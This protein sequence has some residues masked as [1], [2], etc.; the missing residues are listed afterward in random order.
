LKEDYGE[1]MDWVER[2]ITIAPSGQ[3]KGQGYFYRTFINF[4]CGRYTQ[5]L[6]EADQL[7]MMANLAGE[8]EGGVNTELLKGWILYEQGKPELSREHYKHFQDYYASNPLGKDSA[9]ALYDFYDGYA[10]LEMGRLD[11][12]QKKLDAYK[13]VLT[14]AHN[15]PVPQVFRY[16]GGQFEGEVLLRFG[17]AD[18]AVSNLEKAPSRGAPPATQYVLPLY[19]QPFAMDALARAYREMRDID[20]AIAEYEKLTTFNPARPE[21]NWIHPKYHFRLAELYELKGLKDRA[22]DSYQKFLGIWKNADPD[23]PEVAKAKMRL[24]ALQG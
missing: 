19:V 3:L 14:N 23:I 16:L 5:A 8:K 22:I 10:D 11:S 12:A 20:N 15:L 7:L 13:F 2:F 17:S 9:Q 1:A 4:W 18:Q 24:A 21:R 6:I